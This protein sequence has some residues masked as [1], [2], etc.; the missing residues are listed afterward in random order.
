LAKKSPRQK[1]QEFDLAWEKLG[2]S[3]RFAED[4]GENEPK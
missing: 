3:G 1:S 4:C 2:N